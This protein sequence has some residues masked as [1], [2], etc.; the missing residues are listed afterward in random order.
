MSKVGV[1]IFFFKMTHEST[2][3]IHKYIHHE[4]TI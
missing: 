3:A 4:R 1:V 2:D